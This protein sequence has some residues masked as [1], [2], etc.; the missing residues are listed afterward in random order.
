MNTFNSE[1]SEF[2]MNLMKV[3][4][5]QFTGIDILLTTQWPKNVTKY[6]NEVL[7]NQQDVLAS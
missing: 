6:A 5:P 1:D 7:K 2:L 4:N 3:K